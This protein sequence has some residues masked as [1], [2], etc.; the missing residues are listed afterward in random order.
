MRVRRVHLLDF[1]METTHRARND[2]RIKNTI[3]DRFFTRRMVYLLVFIHLEHNIRFSPARC[4][5]SLLPTPQLSLL[6]LRWEKWRQYQRKC[7]CLSEISRSSIARWLHFRYT[8]NSVVR[9][10]YFNDKYTLYSVLQYTCAPVEHQVYG[11]QLKKPVWGEIMCQTINITPV[12]V[13]VWHNFC[14]HLTEKTHTRP[15]YTLYLL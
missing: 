13:M 14:W 9:D 8:A 3:P 15:R 5:K 4:V 10:V 11:G 7:R 12:S 2:R 6:P 1:G